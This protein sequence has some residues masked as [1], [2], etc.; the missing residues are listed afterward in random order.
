MIQYFTTGEAEI[1]PSACSEGVTYNGLVDNTSKLSRDIDVSY[2]KAVSFSIDE[3]LSDNKKVSGSLTLELTSYIKYYDMDDYQYLEVKVDYKGSVSFSAEAEGSKELKLTTFKFSP[4]AGV[5]MEVTPYF[6]L[7]INAQIS[8]TGALT[9]TIGFSCD[10]SSGTQNLTTTP[11]LLAELKGEFTVFVGIRIKPEVNIIHEKIAEA[12]LEA[13]AGVELKGE[14]REALETA[15]QRHTCKS[16]IAGDIYGK[17]Q[18]DFKAVLLNLKKLTYKDSNKLQVKITDFYWSLDY[19]EFAFTECPHNEYLVTLTARDQNGDT[20]SGVVLDGQ[21][22]T[23]KNGIAKFYLTDGVHSISVEKDGKLLGN[24]NITIQGKAK[25]VLLRLNGNENKI[26]E[27]SL[28]Y[29]HSAALKSDGTLWTWEFNGNGQLG[30]GSTTSSADPTIVMDD[31]KAVSLGGYYSAALKKDGSLWM[32][33]SNANGQYGDG[34]TTS[35]T[36]PKKIMSNVKSVSLGCY[37]SAV[38]KEDGSLWMW[39]YNLFKQAGISGSTKR[40]TTPKKIMDGVES[41]SLGDSHSA[42]LKLDGSLWTWGYNY[43]GELGTGST[44]G[45]TATPTDITS[46]FEISLMSMRAVSGGLG[47]ADESQWTTL[48]AESVTVSSDGSSYTA[49]YSNLI[50]GEVY[51]FY[52]MKDSESENAFNKENLLYIQQFATKDDGEL[53]ITYT[54]TENWDGADVF[55]SCMSGNTDDFP[56]YDVKKQDWYYSAIDYASDNGLVD[57]ITDTTF[58]PNQSLTRAQFATIMYRMNGSPEVT[59]TAKFPDVPEG[60]WFTD[61][62]MWASSIGVVEGYGNGCFGTNDNITREQMAVMMHRYGTACGYNVSKQA[63]IDSFADAGTVSGYAYE[64][65]KWTVGNGIIQ[66]KLGNKLDP[67]GNASRAEGAA[68][69]MRFIQKYQ[70]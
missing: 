38:I 44:G 30:T 37:Y 10:T 50:P 56:F 64:A 14:K 59:Y 49:S 2:T 4:V 1:D 40:C 25:K 58:V 31:V 6:V 9:G 8:L 26:V 24:K 29:Y 66:G 15:E 43:N 27:I 20:V 53:V 52:V 35:S 45:S 65:V 16:C 62:V 67:Q 42:A 47:M 46:G 12:S 68:I 36:S 13:E 22:V 21:Y 18:I 7:S 70:K 69:I 54:P 34:T 5:N 39:G 11:R 23:N 17:A 32:W 61:A 19:Q 51:N 28:G 60:Y 55:I 63:E 3:E 48:D 57:G 33:G 41:I